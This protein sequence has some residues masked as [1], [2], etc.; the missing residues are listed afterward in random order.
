MGLSEQTLRFNAESYSIAGGFAVIVFPLFGYYLAY[1]QDADIGD[2]YAKLAVAKKEGDL[3]PY[4]GW[5]VASNQVFMYFYL[6]PYTLLLIRPKRDKRR[7]HLYGVFNGVYMVLGIINGAINLGL[8]SLEKAKNT[9]IATTALASSIVVMV[10]CA[11]TIA[12]A[13]MLLIKGQRSGANKVNAAEDDDVNHNMKKGKT[14]VER[15][16]NQPIQNDDMSGQRKTDE[17]SD[18]T[19]IIKSDAEGET[20][21]LV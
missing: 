10:L 19:L 17:N 13:T 20:E 6:L 3:F 16:E 12:F 9:S 15:E 14:G 18:K 5:V 1:V 4:A 21:K 2:Y 11:L 7:F 8:W